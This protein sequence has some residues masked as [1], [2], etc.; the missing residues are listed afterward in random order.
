MQLGNFIVWLGEFLTHDAK[1]RRDH[2]P[3]S[4]LVFGRT[5]GRSENL[6]R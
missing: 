6:V 1:V 5:R 4:F 2:Q 3:H